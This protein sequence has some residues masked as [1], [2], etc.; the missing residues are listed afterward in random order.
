[1]GLIRYSYTRG[2][3][4]E[5]NEHNLLRDER[6]IIPSSSQGWEGEKVGLQVP[7]VRK[8]KRRQFAASQNDVQPLHSQK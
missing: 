3:N 1:M 6:K 2:L 4:Y 8:L 5:N 7:A